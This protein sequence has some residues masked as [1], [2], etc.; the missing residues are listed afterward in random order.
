M[1]NDNNLTCNKIGFGLLRLPK[2]DD[3]QEHDYDWKSIDEMVDI[4]LE[5]GGT[6]FDTCYTYLDGYSEEAVRR[7]VAGRKPRGGFKLIEKLPGY[8]CQS[9]EDCQNYFEEE[10]LR[11]GVEYFDVFMLHWLDPKHYEI[12]EELGEFRFLQEKKAEGKAGRT[13][14]SYHGDAALLDEILTA[15]PEIDVVLLQINYLDWAAPGI[16]SGKCY[17]TA[18]KHGKS[19]FVMEPVRG[20]TLASL[21]NEAEMILSSIHPDWSPADWALRFAQSLPGVELVLSGMNEK[22]QVEENLRPFHPLQEEEI[23]AL[24][25]AASI[26]RSDT[27]V[28]CTGCRYCVEHCPMNIAIPEYFGLYNEVC[29]YPEDDWKITPVYERLTKDHG[30]ASDCIACRSCEEHCPQHISISSMMKD[31][32]QKFE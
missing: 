32:G 5:N 29:R 11:C 1:N 21:P 23:R 30:K 22:T 14:F 19:I 25:Q 4:Y 20:G 2:N 10:L 3:E 24:A 7:C 18:R 12:A 27:A 15:H 31:V 13:G 6:W 17:E 8:D 16:E 28:P 9:Y 26:I